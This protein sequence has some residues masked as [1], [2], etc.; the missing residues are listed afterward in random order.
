MH[1]GRFL[2]LAFTSLGPNP[3]SFQPCYCYMPVGR[4]ADAHQGSNNDVVNELFV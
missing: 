3:F 1:G 4:W 2:P